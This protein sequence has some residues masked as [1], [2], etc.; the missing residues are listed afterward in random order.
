MNVKIPKEQSLKIT[1]AFC[2]KD[3]YTNEICLK[4]R[5]HTCGIEDTYY[6]CPRCG[7]EY[8]VC[9]TNS[10]IRE[11]MSERESLKGYANQTDIKNY[12]RFK[13]VDAEI[14]RQMKEL[15]HKG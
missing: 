4:T 11:L 2:K 9:Q 12:N 5:M 8:L 13:A 10:E 6:C 7:K 15:N 1:C 14:K 3:F